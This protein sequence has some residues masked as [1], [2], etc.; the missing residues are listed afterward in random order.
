M[1][2]E[3]GLDYEVRWLSR[4]GLNYYGC[5]E[6]LHRKMHILEQIPNLRKVS[7]SPFINVDEA[8]ANMGNRYVFSYKPNPA[9]LAGDNWDL[10]RARHDLDGVFSKAT[11]HNCV[12]EVIMK[13]ISTLRYQ[14]QRLWEWAQMATDLSRQYSS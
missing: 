11:S 7:M 6:P 2:R 1:H 13:D 8:V 14:P 5:C 3:F 10:D 9:V 4:F 12:V